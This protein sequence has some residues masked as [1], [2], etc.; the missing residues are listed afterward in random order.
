MSLYLPQVGQP[1][2]MGPPRT[3]MV[4]M[5]ILA[6]AMSIPGSILS[7]V[8]TQIMAS[9]P[10]LSAIISTLSAMTS[11]LGR[12]I[13]IPWCPMTMP[14][15]TAMVLNSLDTPPAEATPSLICSTSL[16][17]CTWPGLIS[18][19]LLA[20]AI[21]GFFRSSFDTPVPFRSERWLIRSG[22]SYTLLDLWRGFTLIRWK[23]LSR[24]II[25]A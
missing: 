11:R 8:V 21:N 6:A 25:F 15:Q 7:H 16:S 24:H 3:K 20:I 10:W 23:P 4:G 5:S 14:S 19:K 17:R 18:V 1:G 22:P 13:F 12:L 2:S 9:K